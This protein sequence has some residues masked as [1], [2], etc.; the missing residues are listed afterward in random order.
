MSDH[1]MRQPMAL[2][3]NYQF[4]HI[5]ANIVPYQDYL[6]GCVSTII[7]SF[8]HVSLHQGSG[9]RNSGNFQGPIKWPS[10]IFL[11]L[12]AGVRHFVRSFRTIPRLFRAY[13]R[14]STIIWV[15]S[16]FCNRARSKFV[17]KSPMLKSK[18]REGN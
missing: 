12:E 5:F 13:I 7:D 15:Q 16:P 18:S 3:P 8:P 1:S 11:I 6:A 4:I 10:P 2:V 17:E 9:V 14:A